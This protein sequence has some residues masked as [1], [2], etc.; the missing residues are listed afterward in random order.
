MYC[1]TGSSI[2]PRTRGGGAYYKVGAQITNE[3]LNV[4][5][6]ITNESLKSGCAK[7]SISLIEAQKVD[8][9]M[10]TLAH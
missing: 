7:S 4:G 3:F 6:Q 9:Q 10:R 2:A 1:E 5:A 8:A